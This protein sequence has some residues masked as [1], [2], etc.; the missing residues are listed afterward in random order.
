[1]NAVLELTRHFP[2]VHFRHIYAEFNVLEVCGPF[3]VQN[4]VVAT[5][6]GGQAD[7][8][9]I[10]VNLLGKKATLPLAS[11]SVWS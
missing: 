8:F 10:C 9:E 3:L 6:L 5:D 11:C 1:M 4:H 7:L 2:P